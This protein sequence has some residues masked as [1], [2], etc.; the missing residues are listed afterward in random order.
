MQ[1]PVHRQIHGKIGR[2]GANNSIRPYL[3]IGEL[4]ASNR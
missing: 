4:K 1:G 2:W 3:E